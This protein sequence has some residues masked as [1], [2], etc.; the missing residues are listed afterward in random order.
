M[1][2]HALSLRFRVASL[3]LP[4]GCN[5]GPNSKQPKVTQS[6][7]LTLLSH[8]CRVSY[9]IEIIADLER[10]IDFLYN[11][12]DRM[13]LMQIAVSGWTWLILTLFWQ[14]WLAGTVRATV[15]K[16]CR[17]CIKG[18]TRHLLMDAPEFKTMRDWWQQLRTSLN[19]IPRRIHCAWQ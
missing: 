15:V 10:Y 4:S 16:M 8:K 6:A 7:Y 12:E 13:R 18:N 5:L 2:K 9:Q 14:I 19:G 11:C 1:K 17:G 3:S